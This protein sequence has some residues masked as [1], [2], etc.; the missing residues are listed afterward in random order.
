MPGRALE[1][2]TIIEAGTRGAAT[3][4]AKMLADLGAE[5]IKVE[6]PTGDPDR[7]LG[8]FPGNEPHRDKS[9][10]FL[11]LNTNKLGVTLDLA[12]DRGRDT[13]AKLAAKADALI[14]D[15]PPAEAEAAGLTYDA[16]RAA[17]PDIIMTSV[18]PFGMTGP[19]KD[20][21]ATDLTLQAAG[22]WLW[23]NGWPGHPDMPPLKA[24]GRQPS[25]QGGTNAALATMGALYGRSRGGPGQHI[26]ISIQECVAAIL[27]FNLAMWSYMETPVVRYGQ[28]PIHPIDMFQCKD[29]AWVF[30]L[31]IE[32]HQW[33]RLVE[34]METP[35]WA[36]WEVSANRF[37][38]ASNWDALRPFMEEWVSQWTA[39]DLYRAAQEKRIPFAP[40]S[41]LGGLLESDHLKQRGFFVEVTHPEAGKVLHPG[42]PYKLSETPW[43]IRLP[44]PTL[45]QHNADVFGRLGLSDAEIASLSAKGV[46]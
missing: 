45:G 29:G 13:L 6:P 4:G 34:L 12:T 18:T 22:G 42:A 31:C 8:P 26:D 16:V 24:Y 40:V 28:R 36:T 10:T 41:T 17:N 33:E 37:V 5:V 44:A 20:Y 46:V 15:Y 27:E 1:G 35:E 11:Y 9:G 30:V 14:H 38:R 23:M 21:T 25:Y 7:T 19:Q 32:E 43:E 39:D 2:L 3:Y